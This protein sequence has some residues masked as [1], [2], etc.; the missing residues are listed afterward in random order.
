MLMLLG[1]PGSLSLWSQLA[2]EIECTLFQLQTSKDQGTKDLIRLAQKPLELE[3]CVTPS[4]QASLLGDR[5]WFGLDEG[6]FSN[7]D[8]YIR[9]RINILH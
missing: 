3:K 8:Q 5:G 2:A 9:L 4:L 7:R 1:H 6:W